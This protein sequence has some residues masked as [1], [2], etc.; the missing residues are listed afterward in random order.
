MT[1]E[2][3]VHS[4]FR[5]ARNLTQLQASKNMIFDLSIII[6]N[7]KSAAYT[8]QC[9]ASIQET[10]CGLK[11]EVLV[12]DNASYDGCA[13][14]ISVEFPDVVFIQSEENLGFARANNLAFSRCRGRNVLFLNPDTELKATALQKLVASLE[15][16][17]DA[18]MVGAHLL[19]TD[20]SLQTT[21]VVALPSIPNQV[22]GAK[23]LRRAFPKWRIWG[24]S[25]L[26]EAS[27]DPVPV[28]AI[29][30]ACMLAKKEVL[31]SIGCFTPD[32]FMY[33]EDMDLCVKVAKAGRRI[34]YVPDA[35]ITHHAAKSSS[36]R[37][38]SNFSSIKIHESVLRFMEMHRGSH[39]A[40]MYKAST[41]IAAVVRLL[42]LVIASPIAVHPKGRPFFSRALSKWF[43][44]LLW[45]AQSKPMSSDSKPSRHSKA[46]S[47]TAIAPDKA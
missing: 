21:C 30:G 13:E 7:W 14:M 40:M 15:S 6:V 37:E 26:F 41:A 27:Q 36:A 16:I 29:S 44:L 22:L 4:N 31:E 2:V 5:E 32:Y 3:P 42:L 23:H 35:M 19:N 38:E 10:A 8:R 11:F 12:V 34:Y 20:G 43:D 17:P 46:L 25:P 39:Y 47:Q 9:L 33:A 28:E 18:G 45:A 24:M 1:A